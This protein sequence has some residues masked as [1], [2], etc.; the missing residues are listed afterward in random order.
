[1]Q[2]T[3]R[4][5][6]PLCDLIG[7]C[8]V[9]G[10]GLFPAHRRFRAFREQIVRP[11]LLLRRHP[12]VA[13]RRICASAHT[14]RGGIF[15]IGMVVR[16]RAPILRRIRDSPHISVRIQRNPDQKIPPVAAQRKAVRHPPGYAAPARQIVDHDRRLQWQ[17]P[18]TLKTTTL[19]A[20]HQHFAPL[21]KWTHPVEADHT[22]RHLHS[23]SRASTRRFRSKNSHGRWYRPFQFQILN[24]A[25]SCFI[26]A[27]CSPAAM[28]TKVTPLPNTA[29]ASREQTLAVRLLRHPGPPPLTVGSLMEAHPCRVAVVHELDDSASSLRPSRIPLRL[30]DPCR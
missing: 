27:E 8:D 17:R 29:G 4:S 25:A 26:L 9:N 14:L 24:A 16:S 7:M 6:H 30:P 3:T 20:H 2:P 10:A 11:D 21:G 13:C 23:H 5:W 12:G 18:R 22:H 15:R 1:M 19:R 28:S